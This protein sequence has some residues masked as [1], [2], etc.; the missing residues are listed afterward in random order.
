[1]NATD[2][3]YI[4]EIQ[5]R[6]DF[7]ARADGWEERRQ[8]K[9]EL[10]ADYIYSAID[11]GLVPFEYDYAPLELAEI[12]GKPGYWLTDG[13]TRLAAARVAQRR[14]QQ[15]GKA[16]PFETVVKL[17]CIVTSRT[18][19]EALAVAEEANLFHGDNLT[20]EERKALLF[21]RWQRGYVDD[22]GRDWLQISQSDIAQ[23]LGVST[24][25]VSRWKD[26]YKA[27]H[28]PNFDDKRSVV[29]GVDGV[30]RKVAANRETGQNNSEQ[31][32][33]AKAAVIALG[34]YADAF[35]KLIVDNAETI[36]KAQY[37]MDYAAPWINECMTAIKKIEA[38]LPLVEAHTT[39]FATWRL[40]MIYM[41]EGKDVPQMTGKDRKRIARQNPVPSVEQAAN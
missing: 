17:G 37:D 31:R 9:I 6:P 22:D 10:I 15:H 33:K 25:A 36:S 35:Y 38:V 28:D 41:Q 8:D 2:I 30:A 32:Q 16:E 39:A 21:R 26:E 29:I 23:R 14:F 3:L 11:G 34:D 13:F 40:E 18:E 4:D 20:K 7:Q 19:Q 24:S 27:E 12:D 5:T 1:M